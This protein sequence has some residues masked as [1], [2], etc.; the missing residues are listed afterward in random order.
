LLKITITKN[1]HTVLEQRK[2]LMNNDNEGGI[3]DEQSGNK[4]QDSDDSAW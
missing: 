3:S 4:N 1:L 2:K